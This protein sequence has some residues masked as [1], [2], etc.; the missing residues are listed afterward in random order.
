MKCEKKKRTE[1]SFEVNVQI[2]ENMRD[3][4]TTL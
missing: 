1:A 4:K 2:I 3:M